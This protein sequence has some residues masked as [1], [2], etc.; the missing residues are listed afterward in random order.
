MRYRVGTFIL[1]EN[2][3]PKIVN[4]ELKMYLRNS[5]LKDDTTMENGLGFRIVLLKL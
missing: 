2:E 4:E 3:K 1:K 5:F